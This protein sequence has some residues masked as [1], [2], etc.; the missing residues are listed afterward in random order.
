MACVELRS[1]SSFSPAGLE[2]LFQK[3]FPSH[4]SLGALA[5]HTAH[6]LCSFHRLYSPEVVRFCFMECALSPSMFLQ[7]R[8]LPWSSTWGLT[9][10]KQATQG[11]MFPRQSS[12]R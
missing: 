1:N 6:S 8:S 9:P 12:L 11:T 10:A 4:L 7:M 5:T 2:E 3:R